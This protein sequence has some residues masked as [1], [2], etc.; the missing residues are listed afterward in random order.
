MRTRTN[1]ELLGT[2]R[3]TCVI[4]AAALLT[5]SCASDGSSRAGQGAAQGAAIGAGIGLLLGALSGDS[6]VAARAVAVGAAS[7]AARGAYEGW[8]QDQD[9]ERT[10]QITEAIRESSAND[11]QAA[12]DAETR[13]REQLTRFLGVWRLEGW[14]MEPGQGQVKVTA[15]VNGDVH[16]N[17]FVEL[18][19]IDLKAEGF[20]AQVW[21]T[22]TFGYDTDSGFGLSTRFNT[23]QEAIDV[24]GGTFD[25][26]TRTFTFADSEATTLIRFQTPDRFTVTTTMGGETVESYTLT[27]T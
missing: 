19:Y 22:S 20:D 8:R 21:G 6:E 11:Q 12:L 10:R 5:V 24:S 25:A 26:A 9:D 27:R 3:A 16:M 14:L 18:A 13:Q 23:M 1:D 2:L 7:G 4:A 15:Q 17:Y